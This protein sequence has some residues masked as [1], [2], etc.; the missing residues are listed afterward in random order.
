MKGRKIK[1]RED[2]LNEKES[3][4]EVLFGKTIKEVFNDIYSE[5]NPVLK[6]KKMEKYYN[7]LKESIEKGQKEL[8]E[9]KKALQELEDKLKN[10]EKELEKKR[11]TFISRN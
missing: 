5:I 8:E 3:W 10:R 1:K 7:E 2:F 6:W 11:K 9:R 4:S